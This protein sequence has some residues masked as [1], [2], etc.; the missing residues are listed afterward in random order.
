M[1]AKCKETSARMVNDTDVRTPVRFSAEALLFGCGNC[2]SGLLIPQGP[3]PLRGLIP[4]DLQ[5][6]LPENRQ[7]FCSSMVRN[8]HF[9]YPVSRNGRLKHEHATAG[10]MAV[11]ALFLP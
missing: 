5:V 8:A 2:E 6:V 3:D 9:F 7:K 1:A 11:P 4:A 10:G